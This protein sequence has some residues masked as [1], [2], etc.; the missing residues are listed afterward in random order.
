MGGAATGAGST[1]AGSSACA[2]PQ[3][4]TRTRA[5]TPTVWCLVAKRTD[6]VSFEWFE[7]SA[8]LRWLEEAGQDKTWTEAGG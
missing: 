3:R 5:G 2:M 4:V 7:E 1:A 6:P 8:V